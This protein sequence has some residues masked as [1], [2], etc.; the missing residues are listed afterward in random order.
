MST[1]IMK[2]KAEVLTMI[3]ILSAIFIVTIPFIA[4][5]I[6]KKAIGGDEVEEF[7]DL[8]KGGNKDGGKDGDGGGKGGSD[9]EKIDTR[10]ITKS[11]GSDGGYIQVG[12]G[13]YFV[14]PAG[15]LKE[16]T[17]IGVKMKR[18]K[19]EKKTKFYFIPAGLE[20]QRSA[21]LRATWESIQ[22]AQ[23]EEPDLQYAVEE[24]GVLYDVG[25]PIGPGIEALGVAWK[26]KHFSLYYYRRR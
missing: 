23:E 10:F 5:G 13:V 22:D 24:D 17:E 25:K 4:S 3:L 8:A 7:I 1:V 9:S 6:G 14:V 16:D 20:F 21:E 2:R 18:D 11:I 12:N 26:I 19:K 15:A